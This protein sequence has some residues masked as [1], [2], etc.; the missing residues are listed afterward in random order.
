MF[1]QVLEKAEELEIKLPTSAETSTKQEFQKNLYLCFIDYA[2][3]FDCVVNKADVF[4]EHSCF[5]HDQTDVGNLISSSS[6]SSKS[7]LNIWKFS[8][9]ELLKARSE[10]F[11]HYFASMRVE[12]N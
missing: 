8:T 5:F 3:A 12:W 11:Q 6:A 2:K 1:K 10:N 7:S 9:H 4:L